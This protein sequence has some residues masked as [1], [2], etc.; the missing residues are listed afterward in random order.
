A[1]GSGRGTGATR[2]FI[3]GTGGA[4]TRGT[5]ATRGVGAGISW[6]AGRSTSGAP[7]G[8]AAGAG[9]I[10]PAARSGGAACVD[11][12]DGLPVGAGAG[13]LGDSTHRGRPRFAARRSAGRTGA[14]VARRLAP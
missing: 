10:A 11:R 6:I 13:G 5:L 1:R 9:G 8:G 14:T 4:S 12:S 3:G 7:G 2:S